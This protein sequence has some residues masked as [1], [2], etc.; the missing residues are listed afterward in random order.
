MNEERQTYSPQDFLDKLRRDD[1]SPPLRFTGMAKQVEDDDTA[2]LFAHG[3]NC[4]NWVT[5]PL[6]LI[7]HVEVV[8]I[9][10][11]EDHTHPLVNIEF[12]KPT[13]E[14]ALAFS[15]LARSLNQLTGSSAPDVRFRVPIPYWGSGYRPIRTSNEVLMGPRGPVSPY[16]VERAFLD[17][18][19]QCRV[20]CLVAGGDYGTCWHMC[21][22]SGACSVVV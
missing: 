7:E 8:E 6:D 1:L 9:V 13:S 15:S 16:F 5:I 3:R 22:R 11:C 4:A 18:C 2:I 21:T 19:F 12:K 10:N 17:P 20:E 14:E